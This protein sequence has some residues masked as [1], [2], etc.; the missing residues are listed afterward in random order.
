MAEKM[1]NSPSHKHCHRKNARKPLPTMKGVVPDKKPKNVNEKHV[2]HDRKEGAL[3]PS[4]A[5]CLG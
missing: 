5:P 4:T 3:Q 1:E 2:T